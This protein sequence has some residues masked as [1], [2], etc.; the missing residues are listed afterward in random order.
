MLFEW[1]VCFP[2]ILFVCM[3]ISWWYAICVICLLS[4]TLFVCMLISWWYVVGIIYLFC[5]TLSVCVLIFMMICFPTLSIH[6]NFIICLF[7]FHFICIY[8]LIPL[9]YAVCIV[10]LCS[11]PTLS[12]YVFSI[13]ACCLYNLS[14]LF[15][16]LSVYMLPV[17]F[18]AL[19]VH[20]YA[21]PYDLLVSLNIHDYFPLLP[22]SH[23][24]HSIVKSFATKES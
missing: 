4:F 14:V 24:I 18:L 1:T 7:F 19:S 2:F 10:C 15:L 8:M 21:L 9:W 11:S 23:D 16:T 20:V 13:M 6:I 17:F 12:V 3:I 22:S 5:S